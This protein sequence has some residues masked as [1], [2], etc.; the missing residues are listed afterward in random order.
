MR[1]KIVFFTGSRSEFDLMSGLYDAINKT[2]K[3]KAS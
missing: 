2:N 1:K 3:F